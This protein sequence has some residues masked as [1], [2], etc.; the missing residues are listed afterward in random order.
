MVQV[1]P[2]RATH[3]NPARVGADLTLLT[4]QPYDRIDGKL[5]EEYYGRH[6]NNVIRVTKPKDE[7]GDTDSKNKY[8]RARQTMEEW[9][10]DGVLVRDPSPGFYAYF[11]T[12]RAPGGLRTRRGLA[13][14]VKTEPFGRGRVYPHEET[15]LGPKI[16]RLKLLH[17]SKTHFESIFL[18]YSDP[19]KA[20]DKILRAA[21]RAGP[22]I[23]AR[24]DFGELHRVWRID[25]PSTCATLTGLLEP[26]P[27]I[28]ADGHHRYETAL[29]YSIDA[30]KLKLRCEGSESPDNVLAT[31]VNMEDA[32]GLTIYGT[33]RAIREAPGFD[34][35]RFS[36]SISPLFDIRPG[37]AADLRRSKRPAFGLAVRGEKKTFVVTLRDVERALKILEGTGKHSREWNLLDVNVL[38]S[39]I[40][41]DVLGITPDDL[42]H[43]KKVDYYR[44]AD[45]VVQ[46]VREGRYALAFLVRPVTVEQIQSIT[47]GWERFPQ[48]TTDFYPKLL[49]GLLMCRLNCYR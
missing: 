11:Q 48:K 33:H 26:L 3:F 15:H 42:A 38:H 47:R 18:L 12:Y 49:S 32:R 35:K 19:K 27:A 37:S 8:T 6:P 28:I 45:E 39:L 23:E 36:E 14:M 16:D 34:L 2:F 20:V 21:A 24:D 25:D 1:H 10:R 17:E 40:L 4:A 9:L 30:R 5:Q 22:L 44:H 46:L 13:A 31:L 41:N 43:E 7:P 29:K